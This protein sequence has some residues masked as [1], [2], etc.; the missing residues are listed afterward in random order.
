MTNS[1]DN[2]RVDVTKCVLVVDFTKFTI[3]D[4]GSVSCFVVALVSH[5]H[6]K[7]VEGTF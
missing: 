2:L 3:V 1:V 6:D 7:S 4:D 5:D